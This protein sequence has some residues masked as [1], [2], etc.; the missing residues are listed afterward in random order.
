MSALGLR[1]FDIFKNIAFMLNVREKFH[2]KF[3][4]QELTFKFRQSF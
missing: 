2:I 1:N 4:L 3:S